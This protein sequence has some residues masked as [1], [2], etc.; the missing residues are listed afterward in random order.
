MLG[1]PVSTM[2]DIAADP[3]LEAR[4]FWYD[5]KGSVGHQQRHCGSFAI[6]D[7]VRPPLRHAPGEEVNIDRLLAELKTDSTSGNA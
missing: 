5:L 7:G 3:Q 2:A 6:V 4:D 1:Y